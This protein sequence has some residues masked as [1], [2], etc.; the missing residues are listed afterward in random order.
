M[1]DLGYA[2]AYSVPAEDLVDHPT[3]DTET[4]ICGSQLE[5]RPAAWSTAKDVV[6]PDCGRGGHVDDDGQKHGP[7]FTKLYDRGVSE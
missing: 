3:P 5:E 2:D 1:T 7:A 6:C 4:C